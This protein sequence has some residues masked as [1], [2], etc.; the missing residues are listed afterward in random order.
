MV[1]FHLFCCYLVY[2]LEREGDEPGQFVNLDT[3][4]ESTGTLTFTLV[5]T[6]NSEFHTKKFY[7]NNDDYHIE[8]NHSFPEHDS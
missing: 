1:P 8:H 6:T 2:Q 5:K 4:L 3:S 7:K